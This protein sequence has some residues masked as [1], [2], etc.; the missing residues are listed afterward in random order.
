MTYVFLISRLNNSSIAYKYYIQ[1]CVELYIYFHLILDSK[2][3][4]RNK[5]PFAIFI[6]IQI[7]FL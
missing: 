5:R 1:H 4:I 2:N 6:N 3:I 7:N